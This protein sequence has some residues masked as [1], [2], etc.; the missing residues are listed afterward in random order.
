M[1]MIHPTAVVSPGAR[2]GDG[3]EI[4]PYSVLGPHVTL[5]AGARLMSHVVIDGHTT[6][7]E[8]CVVFPFASLGAQTQDLKYAGGITR[9][10]IGDRTTIREYVTVNSGTTEKEVTRVGS[11]C[12]IMA[13]CHLA[14][15]CVVG[16]SVIMANGAQLSGHIVVEDQA[17]IGGMVGVHQFV[18]I[19]R[20]SM[21]GGYTRVIKDC[22]PFMLVE[23]A[24]AAV[25]GVNGVGMQRRGIDA[26]AQERIKDAH[27]IL[28]RQGL[29]TRQAVEKIRAEIPMCPEVESLLVFIE[30][31]QRGITKSRGEERLAEKEGD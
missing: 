15:G 7:G 6:L 8:Q 30:A 10:E 14:H 5:G 29:S 2:M 27:R 1:T 19:G 4:G 17:V 16:D 26:Q 22:A 21:V 11:D 24:P 31:S 23:G 9:V 13:Y 3:V 12:L 25:R 28:F 18:R 20:L